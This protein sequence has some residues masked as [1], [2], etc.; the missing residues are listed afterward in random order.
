MIRDTMLVVTHTLNLEVGGKGYSDVN[1]YFFKGTQFYDP[2]DPTGPQASRRTLYRAWAR[3]GR[4]P[5]LDTFDCPDPSTTTPKRSQT[6][7]P[8]ARA[9]ADESRIRTSHRGSVRRSAAT[10][11]QE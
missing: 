7:T 2:I 11:R 9:V 10:R 3:G 4:N 8:V 6:T 5:W 1:S